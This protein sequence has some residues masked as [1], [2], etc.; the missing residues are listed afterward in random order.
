M[1]ETKNI[2]DSLFQRKILKI[3]AGRNLKQFFLSF[4]ILAAWKNNCLR[5]SYSVCKYN[6][7]SPLKDI[8]NYQ[9][10]TFDVFIKP[11]LSKNYV[12]VSSAL[13]ICHFKRKRM[14]FFFYSRYI[15]EIISAL[16]RHAI[17]TS[18]E[19]GEE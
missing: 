15:F 18:S 6:E 3:F 14:Y 13:K 1:F 12:A 7:E 19:N 4:K 8:N 2:V 10:L 11:Q 17:V 9:K 16:Y 5:F